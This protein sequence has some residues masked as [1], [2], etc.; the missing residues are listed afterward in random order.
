MNSTEFLYKN[1]RKSKDLFKLELENS[2]FF[3]I[4]LDISAVN[5]FQV[6]GAEVARFTVDFNFNHKTAR[7]KISCERKRKFLSSCMRSH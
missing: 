3:F 7:L 1:K 2:F 5:G 6:S 4:L